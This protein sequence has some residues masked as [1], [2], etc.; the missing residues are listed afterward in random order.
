MTERAVEIPYAADTALTLSPVWVAAIAAVLLALG[1]LAHAFIPRYDYR[2][3]ADGTSLII[4]DR[5][6]G[7]FQRAVYDEKGDLTLQRVL[8]PF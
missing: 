3:S 7:K 4:Y 1:V 5:W 8:T 2:A 6:G